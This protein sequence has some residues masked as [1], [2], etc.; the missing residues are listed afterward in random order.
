MLA[1][2]PASA[3][4]R[5]AATGA[6]QEQTVQVG[7]WLYN[8]YSGLCAGVGSQLGNGAPAIQWGC[9]NSTDLHWHFTGT[10]DNNGDPA[11]YLWNDDSAKCLGV[12]SSLA[13]GAQ[14][15]QYTCNGAVDQKWWYGGANRLRNV[16]SG[17]CLGV[18]SSATPGARLIQ[19]TCNSYTNPKWT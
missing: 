4:D 16:Y 6:A 19:W 2:A 10:T 18:G 14:A 8:G 3:L 12:G 13:S 11:L 7:F 5:S 17:K 1:T 15:I 9:N